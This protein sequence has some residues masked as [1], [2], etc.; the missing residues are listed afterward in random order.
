MKILHIAYFGQNRQMNG[1]GEAVIN[2]AQAQ[3]SQGHHV[4]LAMGNDHDLIDGQFIFLTDTTR[5]FCALLDEFSPDIAV[6]HSLYEKFQIPFSRVLRKRKI[7]YVLVFHGGA[8]KDNARKHALKKRIANLI[9]FNRIIRNA[10]R[11]VYLNDNEKEKS[12]FR[13]LNDRDAII[14]NGV[15]LPTNDFKRHVDD[16]ITISFISR[17]DYWGKGL[18]VLSE[19]I[20]RLKDLSIGSKLHFA[21]YGYATDDTYKVFDAMGSIS[22]YYGYVSGQAKKDAFLSSDVLIL[23]SRSEGMP[24]TI[25]EALSYG[26]PCIVTQETNMADIISN[27]NSGWVTEL[28]ADCIVEVVKKCY[29]DIITDREGYFKRCKMTASKYSWQH[30]AEMT[31]T[32]YNNVLNEQNG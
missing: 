14:P 20:A 4:K 29:A 2:L 10:E 23:P 32:M 11:V 26:V 27:S 16:K 15:N 5:N 7:P 18:D 30:I 24:M 6:F 28:S 3:V 31:I 25:L 1:V 17:M 21:F 9:F 22:H 13:R 12:V 19:A 8:S